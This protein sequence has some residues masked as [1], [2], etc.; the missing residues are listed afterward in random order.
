MPSHN[1]FLQVEHSGTEFVL[2]CAD[3]N[4]SII[5]RDQKGFPQI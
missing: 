3:K 4:S 1:S 5:H 2:N